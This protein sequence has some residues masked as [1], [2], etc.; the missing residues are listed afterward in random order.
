M[1]RGTQ[2]AA[3]HLKWSRKECLAKNNHGQ[4]LFPEDITICLTGM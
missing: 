2:N 4:E 3:K 1:H